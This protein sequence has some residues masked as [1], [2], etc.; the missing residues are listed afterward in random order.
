M[1]NDPDDTRPTRR[2][3]LASGAGLLTSGL[4]T[5]CTGETSSAD[6][7]TTERTTT[8]S[9][10]STR[11]ATADPATADASYAVEMAPVGRVE[12]DAVP[13]TW[14]ANNGSWADMGIA[15]GLE[16]PAGVWLPGRYHTRYYDA[17]PGVS[18]DGSDIRKLW[19][20]G[21]VG[22]EQFYEL[23]ADVHVMDPN[24]L[25]N[26]GK[27]TAADVDEIERRIAPF[28]GNSIFSRGYTWHEYPYYTLYE[29]F[30]T[31]AQ[32]FQREDRYEAFATLHEEFQTGLDSVVPVAGERPS[33]AVV[34]AGGDEPEQF[35][36]YVVD[37]GTSFKH[38][39]DLKVNDALASTDVKDF[40]SSR[41]A[42][43]FE[44]LL[45]VDPGTL[46]VRGQE[47]KT[48]AEF[49]ETVVA[50]MDAHSVGGELTAV[51]NG[52]VYR[53]GPLYQGP[54]TNLVVTERLASALYGV[55]EDLFDREHVA[56]IV[57][58]A[59]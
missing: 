4:L 36:P 47:S 7:S 56:A 55:E 59:V 14:V 33:A 42:I 50:F 22:K 12:F 2:S 48:R 31:L 5:G 17:V 26:R 46:L 35:Y 13:E 58:G 23:D 41:G 24:F 38:L 8:S 37:E 51:Q 52:N 57:D 30:G 53:A 11:T 3:L 16:P 34:W 18:V 20:D 44:T 39:R 27:W 32:V 45:E 28:F 29:A 9:A 40:H 43:D 10:A 21:G 49:E 15:L 54:I 19:G 1:T 6:A 25:Q